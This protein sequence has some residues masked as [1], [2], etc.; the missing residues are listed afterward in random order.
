MGC[1]YGLH[2]KGR[3]VKY[4]HCTPEPKESNY[5]DV[6]SR[7]SVIIDLTYTALNGVDVTAADIQNAYLQAPSSEKH[8]V[9][10]GKEFGL[11]HEGNIALIRRTRYGG[12]L[13]SRDFWTRLRSC[14]IFLG[15]KSCQADPYI[16]MR[17]TTKTDETDYWEYVILYVDDGLVV[18][19]HYE[20]MLR[21]EIGKYF[22]I[23]DKSIGPPD[24]CLGGNMRRFKL[25]NGYKSWAFS[26]SQYGV[27]DV[28]NVEEYLARREKKL[29]HPP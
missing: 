26:S 9:I 3:W 13:A 18:S 23:K 20:N 1:K 16:W 24:V 2:T 17:E 28:N 5:A 11:K 7:D 21:E 29:N 19:D 25:E 15:F 6:V 10:C 27:E 22:K 14:M 4:G 12:K 8:Y